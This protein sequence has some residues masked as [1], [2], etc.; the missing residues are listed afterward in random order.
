MGDT[1]SLPLGGLLGYTAVVVRN[2]PLLILIGGVF[3][4]ESLS[5]ILQVGYYKMT[6]KPGGIEGRRLF[7]CAPLHHHF[8]LG[9]WAEPKVVVRFW[10]LGIIFAALS[11]ATLKLR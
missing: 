8:H 6:K 9:G 1:G 4:M 2:E 7:R 5:V 10:L 3:V 11:L